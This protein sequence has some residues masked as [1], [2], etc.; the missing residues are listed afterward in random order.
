MRRGVTDTAP[1]ADCRWCPASNVWAAGCIRRFT[2]FC[3]ETSW[4][5]HSCH[6]MSHGERSANRYDAHPCA[7]G[8]V[9]RVLDASPGDLRQK[10]EWLEGQ[11]RHH[12]A[13]VTAARSYI[14]RNCRIAPAL[15]MKPNARE[16]SD[17]ASV[18]CSCRESRNQAAMKLLK[19]NAHNPPMLGRERVHLEAITRYAA[20]MMN[21]VCRAHTAESGRSNMFPRAASALAARD[22]RA[23]T[24]HM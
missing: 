20:K 17:A 16:G 1:L 19:V 7:E 13:I 4:D 2:D 24:V 8:D 18:A 3:Q 15:L 11:L 21:A 23:K 10:R 5:R 6:A 14:L 12:L 22:Q 9:L